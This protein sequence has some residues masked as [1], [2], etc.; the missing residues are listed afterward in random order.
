[1]INVGDGSVHI[2][3][4][5][6]PDFLK[7]WMKILELPE[8]EENFEITSVHYDEDLENF[9]KE[10]SPS[11]IFIQGSG[12]NSYS[13]RSP[14]APKFDWFKDFNVNTNALYNIINEVK[15]KKSDEEVELMKNSAQICSNAHVFVMKNI[16][17]GMS[18]THV[19]TL[20]RVRNSIFIYSN[21]LLVPI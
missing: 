14:I 5:K 1:L 18:E 17:P 4:E 9:V 3:T 11:V 20:F 19:Q 21:L 7:Y 12:T 8:Y 6:Q 16:K 13:G 15:V 2:F 10:E